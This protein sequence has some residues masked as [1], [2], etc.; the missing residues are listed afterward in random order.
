LR[1]E[2]PGALYHAMSRGNRREAIFR[3]D[4]DRLRFLDTL[5]EACPK[6]GWQVHAYCLMDNHFHLVVETPKPNLVAGMKWLLGTSTQRFN[7][8][9]RLTGYL[10]AGRY[11][12]QLIDP[13]TPGYLVTAADYVH[14][15]PWRANLVPADQ[16]LSQYRWS[17]Y[18][19]YLRPARRPPWLRV[20][21]V[22][23][24]KGVRADTAA[25]R[26]Q[27]ARSLE[28]RREGEGAAG[29]V[30]LRRGWRL[31]AEDLAD[32]LEGR[33]CLKRST[34]APAVER[35][36]GDV[37]AGRRLVAE[38]LK[39]A[40]WKAADL[41]RTP[42][43]H[44]VKVALARTLRTQ[45]PLTRAWIADALKMGSASYLSQLLSVPAS[46]AKRP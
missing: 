29:W 33:M 27:F 26:R 8:R 4:S 12:A 38:G 41:A 19:L 11:K 44:A 35:V 6:C 10:F 28:H 23:G 42:K 9:H 15:N 45:T 43:G 2:F 31:G 22:L 5:A 1:I 18:P 17:S 30:A 24:E 25:G 37:A 13:R 3:N 7:R 16:P 32:W 21:R 36:E 34:S 14:L 46:K 20:D 39:A 40:G